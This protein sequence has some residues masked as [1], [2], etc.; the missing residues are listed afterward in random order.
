MKVDFMMRRLGNILNDDYYDLPEKYAPPI[1]DMGYI[2]FVRE[3]RRCF[4]GNLSTSHYKVTDA[5][6]KA[7]Q[8]W[9][10]SR[11]EEVNARKI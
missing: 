10:E 2:E 6:K 1:Q 9:L 11:R 8:E 4:G 3:C 7:Y 5:G